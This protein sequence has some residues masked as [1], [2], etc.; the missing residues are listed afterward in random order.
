MRETRGGGKGK[1]VG[2]GLREGKEEGVVRNQGERDNV[3][4][5]D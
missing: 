5:E 3:V 4:V 2:R 1:R